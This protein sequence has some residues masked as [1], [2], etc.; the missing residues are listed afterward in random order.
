[1]L[2]SF[3]SFGTCVSNIP[4]TGV[5]LGHNV[6]GLINGLSFVLKKNINFSVDD[7]FFDKEWQWSYFNF[8]RTSNIDSSLIKDFKRVGFKKK[9]HISGKQCNKPSKILQNAGKGV[10]ILY[11]KKILKN[12]L[13]HWKGKWYHVQVT[14]RTCEHDYFCQFR[15]PGAWEFVSSHPMFKKYINYIPMSFP[16]RAIWHFRTGDYNST[17]TTS[18][19]LKLKSTIDYLYKNIDHFVITQYPD[20]FKQIWPLLY[21][22]F[23]IMKSS[24]AHDDLKTMASS[25]LLITTGSSFSYCAALL[26][27]NQTHFMYPPKESGRSNNVTS[28]IAFKTY[29]VKQNTIPVS[30]HGNIIKI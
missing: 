27:I 14:Q 28:T 24:S 26:S 23:S 21:P 20:M 5:S 30:P 4:H 19:I 15:A 1:M 8:P 25:R 17:Q 9:I 3:V 12:P 7:D 11:M 6:A 18:S 2:K 22:K 10:T 13:E 16:K 29:F